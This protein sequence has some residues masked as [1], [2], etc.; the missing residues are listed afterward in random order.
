MASGSI[1]LLGQKTSSLLGCLSD[2]YE[3]MHLYLCV[4]CTNGV[5]ESGQVGAG[6][7]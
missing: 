3:S 5:G 7:V 2:V 6:A 1:V 4:K